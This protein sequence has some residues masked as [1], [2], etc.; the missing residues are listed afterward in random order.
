MAKSPKKH[1]VRRVRDVLKHSPKELG[2]WRHATAAGF[3]ELIGRSLSYIRNVECGS[4]SQWDKLAERIEEKTKVSR[5]WLLS[6]PSPD[7]PVLDCYGHVWNPTRYLDDLAP[8]FGMP[9]WRKLFNN[10]PS[11][12]TRIMTGHLSKMLIWD[13][14]FGFTQVMADI[15]QLFVKNNAHQSPALKEASE[16]DEQLIGAAFLKGV[17]K[18]HA[19]GPI[20]SKELEA[21]LNLDLTK[22][23]VEDA[24]TILNEEGVGWI[25]RLSPQPDCGPIC[26]MK[27]FYR[28][29]I[30]E[31]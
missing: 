30:G 15:N 23:T 8:P 4:V 25:F 21:R 13:L 16:T 27:K 11:E 29:S 28:I 22:L 6:N 5:K 19:D 7:E 31:P 9:D 14:S 26:E 17:Y 12:V 24:A 1:P 20:D 2:L 3:S 10:A 18:N